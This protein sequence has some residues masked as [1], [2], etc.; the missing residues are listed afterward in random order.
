MGGINIIIKCTVGYIEVE[1]ASCHRI[2][3]FNVSLKSIEVNSIVE[4][5]FIPGDR[6]FIC[7]L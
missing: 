4:V 2:G 7:I 3:G 6:K 1:V 5:V